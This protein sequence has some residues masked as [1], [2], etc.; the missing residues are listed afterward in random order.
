MPRKRLGHKQLK[1]L[2]LLNQ[3]KTFWNVKNLIKILDFKGKP[4]YSLESLESRG[5]VD[6]KDIAGI[7]SIK[8]TKTGSDYLETIENRFH[9]K[10]E[11]IDVGNEYY[12]VRIRNPHKFSRIRLPD[13]AERLASSISK[14][15]KVKMGKNKNSDNWQVQS[16]LIRRKF[17]DLEKTEDL[18]LRI[19]KKMES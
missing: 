13:Y 15:S 3:D 8:I 4:Y 2:K 1:I 5:L 19:L 16:I 9:P 11:R 6:V 17:H 12:H 7:D 18:A 14:D 10:I